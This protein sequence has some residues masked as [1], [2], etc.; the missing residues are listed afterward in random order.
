MGKLSERRRVLCGVMLLKPVCWPDGTVHIPAGAVGAAVIAWGGVAPG[1]VV[2]F[3]GHGIASVYVAGHG[4]SWL[5]VN[6]LT[7]PK[8]GLPC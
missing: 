6:W 7:A 8:A 3:A 2:E 5:K 1:Y 4:R